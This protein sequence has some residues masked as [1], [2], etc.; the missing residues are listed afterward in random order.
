M[1]GLSWARHGVVPAQGLQRELVPE[2]H[3]G[4]HG[5]APHSVHSDASKKHLPQEARLVQDPT[6]TLC[7]ATAGSQRNGW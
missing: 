1:T 4:A 5:E 7:R 6:H 3:G 2:E